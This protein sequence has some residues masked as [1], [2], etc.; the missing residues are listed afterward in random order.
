MMSEFIISG[1][2]QVSAQITVNNGG[3]IGSFLSRFPWVLLVVIYPA[4]LY[5]T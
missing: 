2:Q 3:G 4:V 5:Q 1:E